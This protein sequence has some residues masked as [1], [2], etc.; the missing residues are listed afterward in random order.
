MRANHVAAVASVSNIERA[1]AWWETLFSRS[2]INRPMPVLVEWR[3][4]PGLKVAAPHG[5]TAQ[6]NEPSGSGRTTI[7][8][9]T[10]ITSSAG[11]PASAACALT[12]SASIAW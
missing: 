12:A 7:V 11:R 8:S 1:D 4:H 3:H 5:R 9:A 2:V 10:G 6:A